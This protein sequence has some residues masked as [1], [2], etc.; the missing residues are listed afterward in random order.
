MGL[1]PPGSNEHKTELNDL[2]CHGILVKMTV[3]VIVISASSGGAGGFGGFGLGGGPVN[4][5]NKNPFGTL[6]STP[7]NTGKCW[8]RK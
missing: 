6:S 4:D 5:P 2:W 1:D 8:Y 7:A 3:L